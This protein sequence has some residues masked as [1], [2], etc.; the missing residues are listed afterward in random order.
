MGAEFNLN[1]VCIF[2]S[3]ITPFVLQKWISIGNCRAAVGIYINI[4]G[5][6]AKNACIQWQG[7]TL[8]NL[9][10]GGEINYLV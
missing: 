4:N 2:F 3:F 10:I 8:A 5:T 7:L 9:W 1:K 6:T